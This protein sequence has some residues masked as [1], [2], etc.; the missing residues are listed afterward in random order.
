M[1]MSVGAWLSI[2]SLAGLVAALPTVTDYS[3]NYR[4]Y[5]AG[6]W[7]GSNMLFQSF[8]APVVS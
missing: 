3:G 8:Q 6:N 2:L 5:P 4:T 7:L 1:I